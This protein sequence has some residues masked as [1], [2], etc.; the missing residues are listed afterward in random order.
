[1]LSLYIFSTPL[2]RISNP[3]SWNYEGHLHSEKQFLLFYSIRSEKIYTQPQ[4][5]DVEFLRV[6]PRTYSSG[7][8]GS[9]LEAAAQHRLLPAAA[10]SRASTVATRPRSL[11]L[12]SCGAEKGGPAPDRAAD[13][14]ET[15]A[16]GCARFCTS[17]G[18]TIQAKEKLSQ[19]KR[20]E[21]ALPA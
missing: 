15:R 14:R 20:F 3:S 9:F 1:M 13:P 7:L 17:K 16:P 10:R 4:R 5:P 2:L 6:G 11:S 12:P 21:A 18:P 8:S 19:C